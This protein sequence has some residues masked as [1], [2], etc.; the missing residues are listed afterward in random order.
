MGEI[1]PWADEN[2]ARRERD[3]LVTKDTQHGHDHAATSR[4]TSEDYLRRILGSEQV[5]IR[6][7]A[8]LQAAREG[9]LRC[10]A[11]PGSKDPGAELAGVSLHL[12]SV[13]VDAAEEVAAAVDVH[14]D[15]CSNAA[16]PLALVGVGAHLDP[17]GHQRRLGLS[18]LPPLAPADASDAILAKLGLEEGGGLAQVVI[19]DRGVLDLDVLRVR[20]PLGSEGLELLDGVVRRE[21]EKCA[22]EVKA[23]VVR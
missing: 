6:C 17:L 3:A 22:D 18:P 20:N 8:V 13:L 2:S 14:H 16:S 7:D 10:Q 4:V 15:P 21:E 1:D 11:V 9:E 19:R 5:Q 12:I 23:L